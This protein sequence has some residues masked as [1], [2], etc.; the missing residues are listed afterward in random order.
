MQVLTN[1]VVNAIQAMPGGG[2]L[3]IKTKADVSSVL[4][5]MEDTG[6]GMTDEVRKKIFDPFFSTKDSDQGTGLG[7]SIVQGIITSHGGDIEVE[8]QVGLGTKFVIRL[9][10]EM[11]DQ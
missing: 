3:T 4:L 5:I 6:G 8:S 11:S 9:P 7:L 2:K 10:A 1:L